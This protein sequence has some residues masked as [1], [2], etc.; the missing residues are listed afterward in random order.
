MGF[1]DLGL[2]QLQSRSLVEVSVKIGLLTRLTSLSVSLI[3]LRGAVGLTFF[4]S[5]SQL[6]A[7]VLAEIPSG[8]LV[9]TSLVTLNVS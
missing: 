8:V 7:N 6:R 2:A 9:L 4:W 1:F 3:A 5:I